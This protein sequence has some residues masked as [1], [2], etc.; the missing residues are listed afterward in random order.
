LFLFIS[1]VRIINDG[2]R[3]NTQ[4]SIEQFEQI[5][6]KIKENRDKIITLMSKY[7]DAILERAIDTAAFSELMNRFARCALRMCYLSFD[8]NIKY[9]HGERAYTKMYIDEKNLLWRKLYA[10]DRIEIYHKSTDMPIAAISIWYVGEVL[11]VGSD[12][13]YI[14]VE[15]IESID[16]VIED[17]EDEI[18][19]ENEETRDP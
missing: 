17:E 14:K 5:V 6:E 1:F 16:V 2:G 9:T 4:N 19:E 7:L 13:Y 10:A 11:K 15:K 3:V 18:V 8:F 12:S